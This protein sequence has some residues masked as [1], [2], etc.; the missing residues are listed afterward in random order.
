MFVIISSWF[1]KSGL[2]S[3]CPTIQPTKMVEQFF[4]AP[5]HADVC[6]GNKTLASNIPFGHYF[7]KPL[8]PTFY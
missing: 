2:R 5:S 6:M 1:K 8:L 7:G 3:P 4:I